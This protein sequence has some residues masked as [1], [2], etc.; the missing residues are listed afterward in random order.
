[1]ASTLAT[2]LNNPSQT[3]PPTPQGPAP[4]P[5]S[6]PDQDLPSP[7]LPGQPQQPSVSWNPAQPSGPAN[8][9][10]QSGMFHKLFSKLSGQD[11]QYD[12][13]PSTGQTMAK[14]V[15]EKPGELFRNI[16]AAGL[17]GSEGIGPSHGEHTFAQGL[18]AGAGAGIK[19]SRDMAEKQDAARRQQAQ[20]NYENQLRANQEQ[21]ANKE[22]D[23]HTQLNKVQIAHENAQLAVQQ[24]ILA[25]H[26]KDNDNTAADFALAGSQNIVSGYKSLGVE[27]AE[28]LENVSSDDLHA[29]LQKNPGASANFKVLPTGKRMTMVKNADGTESPS[30]ENTYSAYPIMNKVPET[31]ITEMKT[32]GWDDPKNKNYAAYKKMEDDQK[33]GKNVNYTELA[34][35]YGNLKNWEGTQKTVQERKESDARIARDLAEANHSR[36]SASLEL[37]GLKDKKDAE[38]TQGLFE[39]HFDVGTGQ[40]TNMDD[41]DPNKPGL[42]PEEKA[43]RQHDRDLFQKAI[44]NQYQASMHDFVDHYKPT[45]D[46]SGNWVSDDPQVG[47]LTT[48]MNSLKNASTTLNGGKPI[49][50]ATSSGTPSQQA[51]TQ[52]SSSFSGTPQKHF[53]GIIGDPASPN[54]PKDYFSAKRFLDQ[55]PA[56]SDFTEQDRQKVDDGFKKYYGVKEQEKSSTVAR[57]AVTKIQ[58]AAPGVSPEHAQSIIQQSGLS[59][60]AISSL[61]Q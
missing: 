2:P 56:S 50:G 23:M 58:Q 9:P 22:L 42:K 29:Y 52:I 16:L 19:E 20:Q 26:L 54:S 40:L 8:Q 18:M 10:Q 12:I 31:L 51:L 43:K 13:D 44:V 24:Q 30:V 32:N 25:D 41:L 57:Q 48:Y 3:I 37:Y 5:I 4:G 35:V 15:Q 39:K 47:S 46:A 36:I 53:N 27:P 14:P 21:R 11:V 28:G 60:E 17:M 45:K 59:P 33:N 38:D 61:K 7:G 34:S 49:S 55:I 1:M 6:S